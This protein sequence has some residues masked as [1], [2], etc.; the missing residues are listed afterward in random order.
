M[1]YKS[2]FRLLKQV[3]AIR[4][5]Q[6]LGLL[7]LMLVGA[8]AEMATLGA[9]IPFLTL[10]ASPESL[11]SVSFIKPVFSHLPED[12]HSRIMF[13]GIAFGI[14]AVCTA[15]LR[16]LL[17]W[18]TYRFTYM[19][20]ADLGS[21]LFNSV[22]N[23]SY[24]WH[25]AHNTSETISSLQK[26]NAVTHG[27]ILQVLQVVVST[28]M[29]VS[30]FSVLVYIDWETA[31]VG[32]LGFGLLYLVTAF[33]TRRWLKES[34]RLIAQFETERLKAIQQGLGNIRDVILD[35]SQALFLSSFTHLD[36]AMRHSQATSV[37]LG[38]SPRYIIESIGMILI[39]AIS[40][41]L[42][43]REGSFS[44]AIPVL[45]AV[46]MG[47]QKLLPQLHSIYSG[48]A[49][50]TGNY[51]QLDDVLTLLELPATHPVSSQLDALQPGQLDSAITK[52]RGPGQGPL[53]ELR[54][55]SFR[56]KLGLPL[57]HNA[58]S[59]R[60]DIGARIGI[61]GSTGCGKST[62]IDILMGL[63]PPSDGQVMVCGELLTN[64]NIKSWQSRISHVP[65][66]I[67]LSDG[68]I[69]ENIAIGVKPENVNYNLAKRSA[70]NAQLL[71]FIE[72]LP[73]GFNTIVGERGVRLSGGQR[74]RI[75]IARALY[76][77]ADILVLDEAT[78]ALDD[79]TEESIMNCINAL[80]RS[81]TIIMVAHR[82]T[83]LKYT[84]AIL[85]LAPN[86]PP[87]WTD[88]KS[89]FKGYLP[90]SP[91]IKN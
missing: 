8:I 82:V 7:L 70:L 86:A 24:S 20:G 47:A 50:I 22:L 64:S 91:G 2:L 71:G 40:L 28:V 11:Q 15:M 68:T 78:S 67:Y 56:Y 63:L 6:L 39:V 31:L 88:Y 5:L 48:W 58:I 75:G 43:S 19:L 16:I 80:G 33:T 45:G 60:I 53:I 34:S 54:R 55:V 72:T 74:Q 12:H 13:A 41:W 66:A 35:N 84:D 37:F 36:K 90:D 76:R 46:A 61:V 21:D 38:S 87:I 30:I 69:L 52:K 49:S 42:T 25:V 17:S 18:S 1:V 29:S 4:R 81:V 44:A 73:E 83:T 27:V 77:N 32:A 26:V 14:I 57:V 79:S 10:I 65:Q 51:K 23:Q 62:L 9:I 59:L 89:L 85:Q 3:S